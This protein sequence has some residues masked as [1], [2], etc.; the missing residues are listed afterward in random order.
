MKVLT[1]FRARTFRIA[2]MVLLAAA[3]FYMAFAVWALPH[4]LKIHIEKRAAAMLN[5]EVSIGALKVHPIAMALTIID[6]KADAPTVYGSWDSLYIDLQMLSSL[7]SWSV[8][9]DA[10]HIHAPRVCVR[11]RSEAAQALSRMFFSRKQTPFYVKNFSMQRG[12]LTVLDEQEH[13]GE[14][15]RITPITFSL[16]EFSTRFYGE[17]NR[18]NLHFS[19]HGGGYFRLEGSLQWMPFFCEGEMEIRGLNL[20][21][22]QSFFPQRALSFKDGELDIRT[23]YR[24]TEEPAMDFILENTE[25]ICR[26]PLLMADNEQWA[27]TAHSFTVDSLE[28]CT[29]RRT[30]YAPRVN[31][32]SAVLRHVLTEVPNKPNPHILDFIRYRG[33]APQSDSAQYSAGRW[34]IS[35]D[36]VSAKGANVVITDSIL[37][38]AAIHRLDNLNLLLTGLSNR[39]EDSVNIQMS[40]ALNLAAA[41]NFNGSL[42]LFP[43]RLNGSMNI[44]NFPLPTLQNYAGQI[45]RLQLRQGLA[46]L[47]VNVR[48]HSQRDS[49]LF[50]GGTRIEN[51]RLQ[52][53]N[54]QEL[55]AVRRA[56]LNGLEITLLPSLKIN[57]NHIEINA[58]VL[59]II[60]FANSE[61]NLSQ[62]GRKSSSKTAEKNRPAPLSVKRIDISGATVH[63][64][65][66][67]LLEP[68]RFRSTG[69]SGTV[70]NLSNQRTRSP[71]FSVQG[72]M[73]GY[74]PF[75]FK[76]SMQRTAKYPRLKLQGESLSQELVPFSPYSGKYLG[77]RIARGQIAAK[78]DYEIK[79]NMISGKNHVVIQKL[80][81]GES[82]KSPHATKLPV[83]LGAA[84]LSDKNGVIDLDIAIEGNLS[85]PNFSVAGLIWKIIGNLIGKAA[86]APLR[87]LMALVG[88]NADPQTIVFTPGSAQLDGEQRQTLTKLSK[89][90]LERPQLRLDVHGHVDSLRDVNALREA[91]LFDRIFRDTLNFS[92]ELTAA[93][94]ETP[95]LRDT[96]FAYFKSAGKKN[97]QDVYQLIE[98]IERS[99]LSEEELLRRTARQVWND[100]LMRQ[101]TPPDALHELARMRAQNVKM[102]LIRLDETL[103][104]R[105]FVVEGDIFSEAAANLK[106]HE[107]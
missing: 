77:Y 100:L 61:T 52:D 66:Q 29:A 39:R 50:Y 59:H 94:L 49:L 60:Q 30:L 67:T 28:F 24:L 38:P 31:L 91:A 70:L 55:A 17:G 25:L 88:S 96:L 93:S 36:T 27:V 87:G 102:E 35:I 107:R 99:P 56:A 6:F 103:V 71:S 8:R 7:L 89:A 86:A 32:D 53:S 106:I 15:L 42:G 72:L 58:P 54:T 97:W 3:A 48:W 101:R 95:P 73:D 14:L 2:S 40:S 23:R 90:L 20:S 74:A 11:Q 44:E 78:V 9:L 65:D 13:K 92:G 41:L 22:I 26:S 21:Q 75:S 79:D 16:E 69:V 43:L 63:Y 85:D 4:L 1:L 83:R 84:L 105:V 68:F 5:G 51:L 98:S 62:I 76:G 10:L 18:Y 34:R 104:E 46:A 57:A 45:T 80:K 37:Q 12:E 82:V 19:N 47:N 81:F 33:E 64:A